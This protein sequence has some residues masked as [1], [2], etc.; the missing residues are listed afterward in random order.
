MCVHLRRH[1]RPRG[2]VHALSQRNNRRAPTLEKI[3]Q[4]GGG[5]EYSRGGGEEY[6][7]GGAAK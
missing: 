6:S 2:A 3:I 4:Q 7:R 1:R 5:D